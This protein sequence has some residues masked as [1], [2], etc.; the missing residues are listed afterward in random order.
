[1]SES[2][3]HRT[4]RVDV[5]SGCRARRYARR[6]RRGQPGFAGCA[7][8]STNAIICYLERACKRRTSVEHEE[9]QTEEGGVEAKK[10]E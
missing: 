5:E 2:L 10:V 8:G 4:R 9:R 6:F 7:E 1:M 3:Q